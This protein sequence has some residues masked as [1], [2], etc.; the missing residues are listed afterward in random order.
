MIDIFE[1]PSIV[2][3]FHAH[4]QDIEILHRDFGVQISSIFDTQIGMMFMKTEEI[5]SYQQLVQEF[6]RN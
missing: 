2:K 3:I 5:Y 1:E 4:Q 6:L